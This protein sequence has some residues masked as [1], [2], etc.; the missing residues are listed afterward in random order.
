MY[1]MLIQLSLGY[2]QTYTTYSGMSWEG[3]QV[4]LSR[5][6]NFN[7]LEKR[8]PQAENLGRKPHI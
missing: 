6:I 1:R 3:G 4:Q 8:L 2:W 5:S 7:L